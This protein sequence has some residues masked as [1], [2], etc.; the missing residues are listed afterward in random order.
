MAQIFENNA[1]E[2]TAIPR[3]MNGDT[4]GGAAG[5]SSGLSMLMGNVNIVLKDLVSSW[6]EGVTRSFIQGLYFWN[7]QFHPDNKIKGDFDVKARGVSSLVA[8]EVRAQALDQFAQS[9]NNP[10]DAPF[11][12]RDVLN[13]QR[14]EALELLDVVKTDDEVK[15]DQN[16]EMAQQQQQ[17][18]L[19]AQQLSLAEAQA[20]VA[21]LTADAQVANT[22]VQ[23][24][25][26]N[27]DVLIAKA[28]QT[29]VESAYA[30][31]QA[32]GVATSSPYTAPAG[33]EILRSAGWKDATPTPSM[34]Q[35]DGPP[36]Q[37]TQ[38]TQRLLNKGQG[39][40]A[41]PGRVGPGGQLDQPQPPGAD[42][43]TEATPQPATGQAGQEAGI[44]TPAT[45]DA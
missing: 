23:E 14:A 41:E 6:D 45:G 24:M 17:M 26:A 27:I 36:V 16:S 1:D 13:R 2:V 40:E 43:G 18:Q 34:A 30:A 42:A 20:K 31:L 35:L 10:T 12:K 21:K 22:K 39:F 8:K 9:T 5:T 33:D 4:A 19:Q 11:I 7:M 25:L 28:V 44:E 38:G 15:A 32:G 29:K 37:G 3:Y